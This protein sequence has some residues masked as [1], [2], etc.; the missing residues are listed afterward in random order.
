MAS[1]IEAFLLQPGKARNHLHTLSHCRL[2]GFGIINAF[3]VAVFNIRN[4]NWLYEPSLIS[5]LASRELV[6]I[7]PFAIYIN[8]NSIIFS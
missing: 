5:L 6:L 3:L 4:F 7:F 1:I 8:I 2:R